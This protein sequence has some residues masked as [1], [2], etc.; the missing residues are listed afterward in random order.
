MS[1]TKRRVGNGDDSANV[2][3]N[4]IRSPLLSASQDEEMNVKRDK[5]QEN[6]SLGRLEEN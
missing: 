6:W 4:D 1:D 2:G 3:K 5:G